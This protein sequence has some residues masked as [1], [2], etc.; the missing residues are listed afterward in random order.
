MRE[1]ILNLG[2]DSF[3]YGIGSFLNRFIGFLLLP[4]FTSYLTPEE[5]GI[6]A[7]LSLLALLLQ[8]V[9]GLGLGAA[10][11]PSYFSG[12][13][14]DARSSAVWT[15]FALNVLSAGALVVLACAMPAALG[16][17]VRLPPERAMLVVWALMGCALTILTTPFSQRV[18]FEKQARRYVAVTLVT[19]LAT[20]LASVVTVVHLGMGV[21]GMV[22]SQ[23][24]GNLITFL[25]FLWIGL[26]ATRPTLDLVIAKQLIRLGLPLVP[27]FACLF[28]LMHA[29][30]YFLEWHAGLDAVGIY[31]MGF[32]LGMTLSIVTNGISTAWFPFFMS[33][34]DRQ[35]EGA[36]VFRR[37]FTYYVI[38][39]GFLC[40]VFFLVAKPVVLF[41]A[42]ESFHAA[43]PVVGFAALAN[44]FQAA[45]SFFLPGFYFAKEV[46]YIA[47]AQGIAA[48][49]AMVCNYLLI[50]GYGIIGAALGLAL[51]NLLLAAMVYIW[52]RFNAPRY[53]IVR[54][55]WGRIAAFS[56]LAILVL[57]AYG[58]IPEV[59]RFGEVVK[60]LAMV[61]VAAVAMFAL[62]SRR[63]RS[64]ILNRSWVS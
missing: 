50:A 41:M 1:Q 54:Y 31:S 51:G 61:V 58:S 32:N 18:Q 42:Q 21:T 59:G 10:M 43:A 25:A 49:L 52:N 64:F 6:L 40:L 38:G 16:A 46:K 9:F 33:Y 5:F 47:L 29:N 55:E 44:F 11:G 8:P 28:I 53:I 20:I 62:L 13:G 24:F 34:M 2:R 30:K 45:C 7:M 4:V 60:S 48:V 23:F 14:G 19:A 15:A 39:I 12:G 35:E 3:I 27:S 37:I 26:K 57:G 36:A 17:L 56:M 22:L 63:E